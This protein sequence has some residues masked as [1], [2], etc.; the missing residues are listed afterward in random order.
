MENFKNGYSLVVSVYSNLVE[1]VLPSC[2]YWSAF[3]LDDWMLIHILKSA[4]QVLHLTKNWYFKTGIALILQIQLGKTDPF[5]VLNIP[6]HEHGNSLHLLWFPLMFLKFCNISGRGLLFLFV[7]FIP[8]NIIFYDTFKF[9]SL[10]KL[11]F[12]C[13]WYLE[14]Q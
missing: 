4:F 13:R 6:T 14:I 10:Q 11:F 9:F 3:I 5:T 7:K 12:V 2:A 1:Q 8:I